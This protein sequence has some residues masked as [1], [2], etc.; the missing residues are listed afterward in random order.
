MSPS[1][2]G[3]VRP[4]RVNRRAFIGGSDAR[5]IIRAVGSRGSGR[6]ARRCVA[7]CGVVR[8]GVAHRGIVCWLTLRT[9]SNVPT[10]A[11]AGP[12]NPDI[13]AEEQ[14]VAVRVQQFPRVF[15]PKRGRRRE[16]VVSLLTARGL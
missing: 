13:A 7:R 10:A 3:S 2:S 14:D 8:R 5:I 12:K 15:S 9:A 4:T 16:A 6:R 11:A 1:S